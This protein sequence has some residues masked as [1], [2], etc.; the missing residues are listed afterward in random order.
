MTN[1][2]ATSD[3]II[4]VGPGCVG[5]TTVAPLLAEG[6]QRPCIDLDQ[7]FCDRIENIDIFIKGRG[8]AA[9]V[10]ANS[11]LFGTI[12]EDMKNDPAVIPVSSG[13]LASDSPDHIFRINLARVM[14]NYG[15]LLLPSKDSTEA[16]DRVV[17]RMVIRRVETFGQ[18]FLDQ[19]DEEGFRQRCRSTFL[20]R[21]NEYLA[22]DFPVIFSMQAPGAIASIITREIDHA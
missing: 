21:F 19:A 20:R 11:A 6:L 15:V 18:P 8:Y 1:R 10:E 2:N 14:E 3:H 7:E 22:L 12:I 17:T 9:Y 16:A 5:K 13:F 4:I